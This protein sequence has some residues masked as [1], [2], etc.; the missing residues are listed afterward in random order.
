MRSHSLGSAMTTPGRFTIATVT[1]AGLL[2]G[3]VGATPA[4]DP[5]ALDGTAWVLA[6]LPGRSLLPGSTA[7]L[8]FEGG[9]AV[10][11]DGCNRYTRAYR[12]TESSLTI[13]PR[14]AMTQMACTP[15]EL[16]NQAKA[17]M[18]ALAA[19][20]SYRMAGDNLELLDD[21]G[22]LL[23]RL[24]PQPRDLAGTSWRVTAY[25]NGRQAV[26]SPLD[27]T[28]LTMS[29]SADG[30]VSGTAGCNR[31]TGTYTLAGSA[32]RLG[33]AAAT[34]MAC[35]KP[36]GIMDQERSFLAALP[37]VATVRREGDQLE[38]RTAD[39]ALALMLVRESK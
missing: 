10:G 32:L 9:R 31:Y 2:L 3:C 27:G 11:T 28:T 15:P 24:A 16:M 25:N 36:E 34:R 23:A 8:R 33:P 17:F 5:P 26:V 13:E 20:R 21:R 39:D 38:M 12:S 18:A 4:A 7:T 14:A 30:K 35:A 29:F 22:A 19:V 6:E 1:L 37:T